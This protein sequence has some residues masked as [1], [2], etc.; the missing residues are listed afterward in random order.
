MAKRPRIL[1]DCDGILS[2]FVSPALDLIHGHT[3]D[4]HLIEEITQWDV[5]AA[6]KKKE[7]EHILDTAVE[8]QEFCAKMPLQPGAQEAIERLRELG[9]V[10]IITSP[11]DARSWV[12]ERT[13]WLVNHFGFNKKQV[14]NVSAKFLVPGDVLLDDSD[15]NLKDWLAEWPTGVTTSHQLALLWDRPWNRHAN[16]PGVNRVHDWD[17]VVSKVKEHIRGV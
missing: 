6:V 15:S 8:H 7:H 10:Y 3:G 16:Q 5:F 14:A 2:D 9:D 1:V 17:M 4:R 12:F 13:R 11:Y